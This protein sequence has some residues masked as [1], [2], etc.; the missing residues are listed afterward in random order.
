MVNT[1]I[2][3]QLAAEFVEADRYH[4]LGFTPPETVALSAY[5]DTT[6]IP[7]VTDQED[8]TEV[9]EGPSEDVEETVEKEEVD[10]PP[11][12]L[13]EAPKTSMAL[14]KLLERIR[15]IQTQQPS[16][17]LVSEDNHVFPIKRHPEDGFNFFQTAQIFD[18]RAA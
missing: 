16:E 11:S 6:T 10:E 8:P 15:I 9:T 18:K 4:G 7:A 14:A 1:P 17:N 3:D 12:V 13:D 5:D 2:Y